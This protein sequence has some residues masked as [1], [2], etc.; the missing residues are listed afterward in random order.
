VEEVK[1]TPLI[2][3]GKVILRLVDLDDGTVI[4]KKPLPVKETHIYQQTGA[5]GWDKRYVDSI[6]AEHEGTLEYVYGTSRFSVPYQEFIKRAYV[7]KHPVYGEQYHCE[8]QHYAEELILPEV[9]PV[10]SGGLAVGE[11][12]VEPPRKL[13]FGM[14]LRCKRCR[15]SGVQPGLRT[16]KSC[17]EC[18]GHGVTKWQ[19][20]TR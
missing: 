8:V 3:D 14:T 1:E 20:S 6:F 12:Y 16:E 9:E 18:A 7:S 2:R 19:P 11:V 13:E 5:P 10:R 15:G 17:T 4:L